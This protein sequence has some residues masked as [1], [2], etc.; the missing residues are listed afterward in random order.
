MCLTFCCSLILRPCIIIKYTIKCECIYVH[1]E[2]ET[3]VLQENKHNSV[4]HTHTHKLKLIIPKNDLWFFIW[5]VTPRFSVSS[6][7]SLVF[8]V[9]FLFHS[10]VLVR[11]NWNVMRHHNNNN[12]SNVDK[13]REKK[14]EE[15]LVKKALV[16]VRMCKVIYDG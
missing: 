1:D 6:M 13:R 2:R 7:V 15:K 12:N 9:C 5:H 14:E 8:F 11:I 4:R 16:Y 3:S 10:L